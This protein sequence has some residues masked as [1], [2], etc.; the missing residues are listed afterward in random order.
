MD[1]YCTGYGV[2]RKPEIIRDGNF[3]DLSGARLDAVREAEVIR[4]FDFIN[5][6]RTGCYSIC[7]SEGVFDCSLKDS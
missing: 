7:E 6:D 2:C 4:N 3:M 1:L 5:S